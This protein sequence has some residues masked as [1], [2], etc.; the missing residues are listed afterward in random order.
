[1]SRLASGDLLT[2]LAGGDFL[3]SF[4]DLFD[5]V[6]DVDHAEGWAL[7]ALSSARLV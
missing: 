1:L 4:L 6:G 5:P 7:K 2:S 3:V